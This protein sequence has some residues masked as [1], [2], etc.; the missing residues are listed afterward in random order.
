MC[1]LVCIGVGVGGLTVFA[2]IVILFLHV[3]LSMGG[4]WRFRGKERFFAHLGKQKFPPQR[5]FCR[6]R[7]GFR[8]EP[9]GSSH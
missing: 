6:K 1:G 5:V 3:A 2:G 9:L 4:C 7:N 8:P